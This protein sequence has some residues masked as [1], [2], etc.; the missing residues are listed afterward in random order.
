MIDAKFRPVAIGKWH[1]ILVVGR[2]GASENKNNNENNNNNISNAGHSININT[3]L[4]GS[5]K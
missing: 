2:Q 5:I 3:V 1:C 4:I